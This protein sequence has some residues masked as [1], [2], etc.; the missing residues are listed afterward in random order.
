MKKIIK[1]NFVDF[2]SDFD[3]YN[4]DFIEVLSERFNVIISYHPDYIFYSTFGIKHLKYDCIRIFYT[5]ECIT[6]DFNECDYAIGFDRLTYRDRYLRIPIYRLFQYKKDYK[7]LFER[8]PF[9][10]KDLKN[11]TGFCNFIYSNCFAQE[12]R[13]DIFEKLSKYKVV[14]SG[15]RY[16]NNIG[17]VVK[18]KK[19]FQ[20]QY[21]FSI[22]FEN[23]SYDGYLT[24][25]LVD[26]F[27]A[28]TI[29]IY[30]GDPR[31]ILDFNEK[32]FINC[33]SYKN[34][35]EVV[36]RVKEIDNNDNIYLQIMNESP[37]KYEIDNE[38]LRKFLFN[39]FDSEINSAIRRPISD[40]SIAKEFFYLRYNFFDKYIY[41]NYGRI[42]RQIMRMSRNTLL[43]KQNN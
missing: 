19:F 33:H 21:K 34:L 40:N 3:K 25:K 18:D 20:Q 4:N 39:I 36:E 42:K 13:T 15:G 14:D 30:Y 8:H 35:D 7:L 27:V 16:R 22:A 23:V 6:P 10:N 5:G 2:T 32:A 38:D 24:E 9:T 41:A 11:K 43:K 1:I 31:V 28:G 29:P 12:K 17:N 26:A 37:A